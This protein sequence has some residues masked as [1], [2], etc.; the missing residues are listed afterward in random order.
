MPP[1]QLTVVTRQRLL[2]LL[3]VEQVWWW[4]DLDEVRF[5]ER[6]YDLD[7]LECDGFRRLAAREDITQHCLSNDDWPPE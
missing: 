4:G 1:Q 3:I 7:A 5:L 2:D 6:L